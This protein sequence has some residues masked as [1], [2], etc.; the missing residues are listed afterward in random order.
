MFNQESHFSGQACGRSAGVRFSREVRF[1]I[2]E[3]EG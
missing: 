1:L 2:N 3:K